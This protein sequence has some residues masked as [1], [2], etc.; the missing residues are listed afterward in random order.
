MTLLSRAGAF[1]DV[2]MRFAS[3]LAINLAEGDA[4]YQSMLDAADAHAAK[5][6]FDL[7]KDPPARI[8]DPERLC[9]SEPILQLDFVSAGVASIVWA[10]GCVRDFG[11][12]ESGALNEYGAPVHRRGVTDVTVFHFLGLNGLSRWASAFIFGA[13][14]DAA[15]LADYIAKRSSLQRRSTG[16]GVWL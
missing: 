7:P 16:T 3:D 5:K 11:W 1:E 15:C 9:V 10:T 2:V 8:V 12:L 14:H 13:E 6:G 4:S